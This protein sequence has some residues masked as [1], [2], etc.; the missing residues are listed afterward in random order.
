MHWLICQHAH[1]RFLTGAYDI[2]YLRV[3][4]R[5]TAVQ[6]LVTQLEARLADYEARM[7]GY[8]VKQP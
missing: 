3:Q 2:D 5:Y 6:K 4:H 1:H 8:I 7:V